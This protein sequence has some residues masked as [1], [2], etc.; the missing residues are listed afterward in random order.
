MNFI[1]EFDPKAEKEYFDAWDW[2]EEQLIGLGDRF[3]N[4][5]IRQIEF[6]SKAPL[7]YPSKKAQSREC[8]IEDFPF[9]II[10]KIYPA[11]NVIYI[12][13]IFHTSRNPRKKYPK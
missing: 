12:S 6:I 10:Y 9:L 2:Y 8:K 3:G 4:S 5:V 1:I 7:S 13:S 11:K